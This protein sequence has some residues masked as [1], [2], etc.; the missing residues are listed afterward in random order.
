M[1]YRQL[2]LD[3]E[4]FQNGYLLAKGIGEEIGNDLC[5]IFIIM[6]IILLAFGQAG[7][8][9]RTEPHVEFLGTLTAKT[10]LKVF[11]DAVGIDEMAVH[12]TG[13]ITGSHSIKSVSVVEC[14]TFNKMFCIAENG[15]T[16][17]LIISHLRRHN[18]EIAAYHRIHQHRYATLLS[19]LT[20]ISG[21][22]IIEGGAW[23]GMTGW[24]RLFIVMA[25]LDNDV[26]PRLYLLQNL[27]PTAFIEEALRGTAINGVI[28]YHDEIGIEALLEHHT[29]ATL[30]LS[31]GSVLIGS[32]GI[33]NHEDSRGLIWRGCNEA[34]DNADD[35][36][37]DLE[38]PFHF[39]CYLTFSISSSIATSC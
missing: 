19:R 26:V 20:D 39:F 2:L 9:A 13:H 11:S 10:L 28:V 3:S 38:T 33:A 31:A 21:E 6:C 35:T 24:L 7:F 4:G 30:N 27:V 18:E 14:I 29:P 5:A 22:I 23:V 34:I 32:G 16:Q 25:K 36:D 12:A 8:L 1:S 17:L 15:V 37:E